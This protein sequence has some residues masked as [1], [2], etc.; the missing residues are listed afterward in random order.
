MDLLSTFLMTIA[1]GVML[2]R[3]VLETGIRP[4]NPARH[5]LFYRREGVGPPLLM[6]HGLA[7]SWRYWRRG[8]GILRE[9]H[10]LYVPD[11]I[12]FGRSPKPRGDYSMTMHVEALTQLLADIEGDVVIA[13]HSMGAAVALGFYARHPDR[14]ARVVLIGLP[15]FP[16]ESVARSPR[17]RELRGHFLGACAQRLQATFQRSFHRLLRVQIQQPAQCRER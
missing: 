5:K 13:G 7:G 10:T 12:G 17:L 16:T 11:L 6:L 14:V 4:F 15:Y 1:M 3:A 2:R 8:L 9:R